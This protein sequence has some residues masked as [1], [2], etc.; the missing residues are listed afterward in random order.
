MK[1][2]AWAVMSLAGFGLML[3][4]Y[5]GGMRVPESAPWSNGLIMVG[6]GEPAAAVTALDVTPMRL[7]YFA[8]SEV[9][10]QVI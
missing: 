8:R 1:V 7:V 9:E 5:Y 2:L 10:L 6:R 3:G 4:A